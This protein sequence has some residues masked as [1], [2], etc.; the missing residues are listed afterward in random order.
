MAYRTHVL[1]LVGELVGEER[2]GYL[3]DVL[4]AALDPDL[5]L[6]QREVLGLSAAE[7]RQGWAQLIASL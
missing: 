5:V 7:L 4:L 6:H 3:A 2:A 1:A